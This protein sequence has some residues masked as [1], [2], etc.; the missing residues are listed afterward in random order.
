MSFWDKMQDKADKMS[1]GESNNISQIMD[2]SVRDVFQVLSGV[3]NTT[4]RIPDN[5]ISFIGA[6]GGTGASTI[7]ANV[8]T[9]LK[10]MGYSVLVVD[11]NITYPIQYNYLGYKMSNKNKFDIVSFMNGKCNIG[12]SINNEKDIS[13]LTASNRTIMDLI[14]ADK[15]ERVE[16][17]G[18]ATEV[19]RD[20]FDF[21][22]I[23]V[24][25]ALMLDMVHTCLYI[26]DKVYIVW[27]EN[28][29][30][31]PNTEILK[32]NM[33]MCGISY[34]SKLKLILNK[35]T[36]IQYPRV[37]VDRSGI[38]MVAVLPFE[39]SVIESGLA[40]NAYITG[41]A[42]LSKNAPKFVE[43]ITTITE[44]ILSDSGAL[45]EVKIAEVQKEDNSNESLNDGSVT[46]DAR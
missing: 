23:D 21:I 10:T 46:D 37:A 3:R 2:K 31:I 26:S 20:F 34:E 8:A 32:K 13:L 43:G 18:K 38:D 9:K 28:I 29:S 22:L 16:E 4:K 33:M 1:S 11:A 40:A 27:D 6:A 42:S 12:E 36:S 45:S 30:C 35:R 44:Q 39:T 25:N 41:G 24:P 7:T 15:S 5:V 14:S 17:F 19:L